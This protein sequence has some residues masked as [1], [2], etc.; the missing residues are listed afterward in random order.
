MRHIVLLAAALL[1]ATPAIGQTRPG[2]PLRFETLKDAYDRQ[3]A[4]DYRA[5]QDS[6]SLLQNERPTPLGDARVHPVPPPAG[7]TTQPA[8]N[9][10]K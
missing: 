5:R 6:R 2:E 7:Y 4:E 1:L 10:R 3:Q 8:P 9:A